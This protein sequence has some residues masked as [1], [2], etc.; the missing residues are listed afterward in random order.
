MLPFRRIVVLIFAVVFIA[1]ASLLAIYFWKTRG[2]ITEIK[3]LSKNF[4][5]RIE[6]KSKWQNFI[7]TI[8]NCENGRFTVYGA[9]EGKKPSLAGKVEYSISDENQSFEVTDSSREVLYTYSISY[10]EEKQLASVNLNFPNDSK[11]DG[12]MVGGVV[13]LVSYNLFKG[14]S[15]TETDNNLKQ[16][17]NN[18]ASLGLIYENR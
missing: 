5:L 17:F 9:S 14:K 12:N 7:N 8:G 13:V 6:D 2:C 10:N 16:F 3:S 18:L 15:M 4:T 11:I 1:S